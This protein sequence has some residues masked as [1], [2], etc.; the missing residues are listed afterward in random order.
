MSECD[1]CQQIEKKIGVVYEDDEIT[2]LL[3]PTPASTGHLVVAPKQHHIILEQVPDWVMGKMFTTANKLSISL[4]EG[5]GVHGT[6]IHI[7]NGEPAGQVVPHI[8]VNVVPRNENDGLN[9]LWQPKQLPEEEMAS[10]EAALKEETKSIMS[11][12]TEKPSKAEVKKAEKIAYKLSDEEN[13]LIKSLRR[14]P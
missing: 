5:M 11:F 6:N 7:A 4:F 14:I 12:I 13:Y 1:L 2:A 9:L 3:S 10:A 8:A